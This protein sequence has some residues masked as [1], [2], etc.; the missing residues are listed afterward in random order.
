MEQ[1]PAWRQIIHDLELWKFVNVQMYRPT[2]SKSRQHALCNAF[3]CGS[4]GVLYSLMS[5]D[6][7]WCINR[8]NTWFLVLHQC[9]LLIAVNISSA[10][11]S[12]CRGEMCESASNWVTLKKYSLKS[13]FESNN[14]LARDLLH[15]GQGGKHVGIT[16]EPSSPQKLDSLISR[17]KL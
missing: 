7:V 5:D 2:Q 10:Y 8:N 14:L 15:L 13:P 12:Q 11:A 9:I 6:D 17:R 4:T 16:K 1:A 3:F